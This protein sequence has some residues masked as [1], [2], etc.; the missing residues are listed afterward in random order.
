MKIMRLG[1]TESGI[2]LLNFIINHCNPNE[3]LKNELF[4]YFF[5]LT[6]WLY[7]SGGFYDK[8]IKISS[9]GEFNYSIW[10]NNFN[11]FINYLE[12][13]IYECNTTQ[14]IFWDGFVTRMFEE[15][16]ESFINKYKISNVNKV[17]NIVYSNSVDIFHYSIENIFNCMKDKKVLVISSFG[18][19]IKLQYDSGN[20]NKI[21]DSFPNIEKI[22]PFQFPY[23]FLNNGPHN[24]YFE[25]LDVVF[26]E[27]KK[28]D[29]DIALLSCGSYGHILCHK[30]DSELKKDAIY[31]G[32]V[33]TR[34]FGILS[35]RE[36]KKKKNIE[37]YNINEYWITEIPEEYKPENYKKIE[38]GCYW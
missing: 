26:E 12:N 4:Y 21:Y 2:L 35:S 27:I 23:C 14:L 38:D 1:M 5:D 13:S 22:I 10:S 11:I 15:Y 32:G 25:T 8:N 20:M 16:K 31:I 36:K 29:F 7:N 37:S 28:I 6:N 34:L 19:L 9:N 24:N 3:E 17:N 18:K 30:I 33:I